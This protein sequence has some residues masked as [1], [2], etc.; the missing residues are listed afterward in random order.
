M[1]KKLLGF[2]KLLTIVFKIV[3]YP[4]HTMLCFFKV[5]CM[6]SCTTVCSLQSKLKQWLIL[7]WVNK[8]KSVVFLVYSFLY[9][10]HLANLALC[11][12]PNSFWLPWLC[13]CI[14]CSNLV[15]VCP[16]HRL[17]GETQRRNISLITL[18]INL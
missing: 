9:K 16:A 13:M 11:I 18:T 8:F 7:L 4:P 1:G 12:I 15:W 3:C 6:K 2:L 14:F 17:Y 10:E 5:L